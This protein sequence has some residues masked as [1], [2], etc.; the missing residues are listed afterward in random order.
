ME[1]QVLITVDSVMDDMNGGN[2]ALSL[3]TE[4]RLSVENNEYV[5]SYEEARLR[6]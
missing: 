1:K 3:V 2:N 6:A 4:G 5:L